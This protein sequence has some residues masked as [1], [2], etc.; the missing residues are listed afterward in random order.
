MNVAIDLFV[1]V[2][3]QSTVQYYVQELGMHTWYTENVEI[4]IFVR[5][6]SMNNF[7]SFQIKLLDFFYHGIM[8]SRNNFS[9]C[10]TSLK[11]CLLGKN[12]CIANYLDRYSQIVEVIN[13]FLN[14]KP[15][16][17]ETGNCNS[18]IKVKLDFLKNCKITG[19]CQLMSLVPRNVSLIG[20]KS[21]KLNLSGKQHSNHFFSW[22]NN[23][24]NN[25]SYVQHHSVF[26]SKEALCNEKKLLDITTLIVQKFLTVPENQNSSSKLQ[27]A[28]HPTAHKSIFFY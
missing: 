1:A 28:L 3:C 21:P 14:N 10:E 2:H 11:D 22:I 26:L 8:T 12:S 13:L 18:I 4:R 5:T 15:V 20:R 7:D 17:P 24:V 6:I 9:V 19:K 23:R 27:A 16:F 25:F